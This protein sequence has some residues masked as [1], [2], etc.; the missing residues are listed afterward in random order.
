MTRDLDSFHP[1]TDEAV[2]A[3]RN[4]PT[5]GRNDPLLDTS[6]DTFDKDI[7]AE[8]HRQCC[9]APAGASRHSIGYMQRR[10]CHPRR[11]L[12]RSR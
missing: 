2:G 9:I 11:P 10:N 12:R 1:I 3:A 5:G 4:L 8:E 6:T 7:V